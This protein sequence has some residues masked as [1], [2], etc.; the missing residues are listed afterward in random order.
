MFNSPNLALPFLA[1][2]QAQKHVTVNEALSRLDGL[3]QITVESSDLNHPPANPVDGDR[4]IV[5][6]FPSGAWGGEEANVA[7]FLNGAWSFAVPQ[8]GWRAWAKDQNCAAIFSSG[9]WRIGL[10]GGE[11]HGAAT[12]VKVDIVD[13]PL[14]GGDPVVTSLVIPNRAVVIGVTARVITQIS[15]S[16]LTSWRM[17][18]AN[19]DNRYGSGIG[20]AKDSSAIGVTG[21]PVA[22]YSDT[23]VVLTPEGGAFDSG[24]IRI[25]AHFFTLS[26]PDAA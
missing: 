24:V 22:Y 10:I 11:E 7:M 9:S 4:Y 20:L 14:A 23:P 18:V 12:S 1:A 16:G 13:V 17:G 5:G 25:A 2:A 19:S 8:D 3:T 21:A 26:A 15:G 6:R